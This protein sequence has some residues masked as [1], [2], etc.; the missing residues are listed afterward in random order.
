MDAELPYPLTTD[1][2]I[3]D[4]VA[5]IETPTAELTIDDPDEVATYDKIAELMWTVAAEGEAARATLLRVLGDLAPP[6]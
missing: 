1:F 2:W 6:A 3:V 4:D 5:M